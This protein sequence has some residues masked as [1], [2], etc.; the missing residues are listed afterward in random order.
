MHEEHTIPEERGILVLTRDTIDQVL[1]SHKYILL[2]FYTPYD[3]HTNYLLPELEKA[4]KAMKKWKKKVVVAK[5]DASHENEL[6]EIHDIRGFPSMKLFIHGRS[7]EHKGTHRHE[8]EILDWVKRKTA[9]P[10]SK[11]RHAHSLKRL[12]REHDSAV[13]FFG[14]SGTEAYHEYYWA[15]R[16]FDDIV[17]AHTDNPAFAKELN[18][19]EDIFETAQLRMYKKYDE[20]VAKYH[21]DWNATHIIEWLDRHQYHVVMYFGNKEADRVFR[22]GKACLFLVYDN[23]TDAGKEARADFEEAAVALRDKILLATLGRVDDFQ[24]RITDYLGVHDSDLPTLRIIDPTG[25]ETA[26]YLHNGDIHVDSI[27]DFYEDWVNKKLKPY[28]RSEEPPAENNAP[29]KKLVGSTFHD[30]SYNDE[31]DVFV[32]FTTPWCEDCNKV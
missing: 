23:R 8:S 21:D 29:V 19:T 12:L 1:A 6:A 13:I 32:A 17:F 30:F 9:S 3:D 2:D 20:K 26:K 27:I 10:S 24:I 14:P 7:I 28:Y 5:L 16:H 25:D 31:K 18:V 11:L 22:Q 15:A 4:A